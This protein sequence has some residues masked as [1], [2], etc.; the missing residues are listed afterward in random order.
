MD[1]LS[2]RL[3]GAGVEAWIGAQEVLGRARDSWQE[4]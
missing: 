1:Q 4:C 3:D 2:E